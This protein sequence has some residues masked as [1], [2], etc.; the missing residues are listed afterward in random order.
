MQAVKQ[1]QHYAKRSGWKNLWNLGGSQ[2]IADHE[3]KLKKKQQQSRWI[4][5][6]SISSKKSAQIYP[7]KILLLTSTYHHSYF[8]SATWIFFCIGP[9]LHDCLWVEITF[10]D[11]ICVTFLCYF[12]GKMMTVFLKC[13]K[14][15]VAT[16]SISFA[17][18]YMIWVFVC[19]SNKIYIFWTSN[20]ALIE[21]MVEFH[22]C[23]SVNFWMLTK[24]HN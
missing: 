20:R 22:W 24:R 7:L 13:R 5:C 2:K 23:R 12:S 8:L 15:M 18:H 17:W 14:K 16:T 1:V 19:Y 4:L 6:Y 21:N 9:S 3:Q 11:L 10:S